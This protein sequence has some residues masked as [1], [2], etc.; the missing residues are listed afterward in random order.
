MK[1]LLLLSAWFGFSSATLAMPRDYVGGFNLTENGDFVYDAADPGAMKTP[2]QLAV[3]EAKALGSNHVNLNLRARMVGPRSSEVIPVTAPAQ[4]ANERIRIAR[5]I[6]YIHEQGMTVGLRPIFLVVGP[7][8][9][10]PYVEK[11]PDG[12]VKTWWHG[13]IQ[14]DDPNR[15]FQSFLVYLD[16]YMDV[17]R[18]AKADEFTIGAE[19]YSMTVGIEDQWLAYPHGFPGR[20]LEVLRHARAKLR[21]TRIMYDINF[22]DDSVKIDGGITASGGEMERWRYRI[23]DLA[24]PSDPD[25]HKIWTDLVAFWKELDAVGIDMYRSLASERETMPE[26]YEELVAALKL[27]SDSYATQLDNAMSQI[28]FTVGQRPIAIL[29]EVGFRSVEKGYIN[30]FSYSGS[31]SIKVADQAAAYQAIF[32][33]FWSVNWPWFRG[34]VFWEIPLDPA[35]KGMADNGFSPLDK[36]MTSSL[37]RANFR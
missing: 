30:P 23:V 32:E 19:L 2:A 35:R 18:M 31:G 14:P 26:K 5:L 1:W 10:F 16:M 11:Q 12:S 4:R 21:N 36:E 3:D 33:S 37:V 27:R 6:R 29:K 17:A 8:G 34:I 9:E 20:W 24:N 13:N 25:E 22:T 15:W 7:N 28:E